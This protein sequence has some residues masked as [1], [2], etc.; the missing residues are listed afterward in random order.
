MVA[1]VE[2]VQSRR[3][4]GGKDTMAERG[5]VACR[6]GLGLY[7]LA[8]SLP[9]IFILVVT[10]DYRLGVCR[11]RRIVPQRTSE[12]GWGLKTRLIPPN[13]PALMP[14][15]PLHNL[16]A[17]RVV[18]WPLLFVRQSDSRLAG[19]RAQRWLPTRPQLHSGAK[20]PR[21]GGALAP[22]LITEIAVSKGPPGRWRSEKGR[23]KEG[24]PAG[25]HRP[26]SR[27]RTW[28]SV[29]PLHCFL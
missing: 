29:G 14:F 26:Q 27:R 6:D 4:L 13:S 7:L 18:A 22:G 23:S 11:C 28:K 15:L 24:D 2:E 19:R 21:L 16:L 5:C 10:W 20:A 12:E 8:T 17:A 9:H 1:M 3:T 25:A